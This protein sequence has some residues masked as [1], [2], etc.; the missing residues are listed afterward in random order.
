[1]I[2][3]ALTFIG[4]RI[5]ALYDETRITEVKCFYSAWVSPK[6]YNSQQAKIVRKVTKWRKASEKS[7]DQIPW[8][9]SRM[10]DMYLHRFIEDEDFTNDVNWLSWRTARWKKVFYQ[11]DRYV[12]VAR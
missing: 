5:D 6:Y 12:C 10:L 2:V 8:D 3:I 9:H 1:M 11:D 4:L 7:M